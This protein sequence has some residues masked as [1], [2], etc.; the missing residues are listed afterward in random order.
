MQITAKTLTTLTTQIMQKIQA[1]AVQVIIQ[2]VQA[3]IQTQP[4]VRTQIPEIL[5]KTLTGLGM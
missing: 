3:A 5:L 2:P 4:D 1:Q